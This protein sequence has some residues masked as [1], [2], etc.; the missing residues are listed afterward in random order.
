MPLYEYRCRQCGKKVALLV[1][2]TADPDRAECPECGGLDL[3]R[4]VSRFTRGRTEDDRIDELSDRLE[5]GGEPESPAEM[6]RLVREMGKAMDEDVSD[7]MEEMFEE[8]VAGG[9]VADE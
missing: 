8:D 2:M 6:R 1:G 4:L 7:E 5:L 9:G 3:E